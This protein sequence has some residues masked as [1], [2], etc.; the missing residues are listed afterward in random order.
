M[1]PFSALFAHFT[2][3]AHSF[4][5]GTLCS[6]SA[7]EG[8]GCGHLHLFRGGHLRVQ[9]AGCADLQ[10]NSPTILFYPRGM[11]HQL[12]ADPERGADLVCA[13]VDMGIASGSPLATGL[14]DLMIL[15]FAE[16]PT[17]GP[18]FELMLDEAFAQHSGRQAAL[19]RLFDYFLI[20]LVRHVI[21]SGQV[22]AGVLAT[23]A[24]PALARA[25]TALHEKPQHGWTL[26]ELAE[27]AGMSR[28]SFATR[29]RATVG[30]TPIDY[31]TRWRMSVAQQLLGQGK[32][33]KAIAA[34]VGYD[35]AAAFSRVFA[36]T[37]GQ[38]PRQW[39]SSKS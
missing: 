35:S 10:L 12:L 33:V 25:I 26:D 34:S 9:Q 11:A 22:S 17:I 38:S 31:L 8:H 39:A 16:V 27:L 21:A 15:S 1:D 6:A 2:P 5:A 37:L 19:D 13:T 20:Q 7:F 18:T 28:T 23:L 30:Q 32:P 14:P 36:R 3:S 4:F 24:D 29:F